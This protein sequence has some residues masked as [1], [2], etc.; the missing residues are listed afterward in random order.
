MKG[1]GKERMLT[2]YIP[3]IGWLR[4]Y[5]RKNLN[6][7]LSAGVTVAIMLVPQS[8]AY[9][10]LAGLP[11]VIGLYSSTLPL[12]VYALFGTSRQLAVGPVAMVSLLVY[13]G[14]SQLATPGSS[15]YVSLVLLLTL[16]TGLIQWI[17]GLLR[18]GFIV[19]FLSHAVISGFTSAAAI[20]I[21]L[22]Q[23]KHLLGIKLS[24]HHS[25]FSL[26]FEAVQK[27]HQIHLITFFLGLGSIGLL[28]L[29]KKN[30]SRFPA[31]LLVVVISTMLVYIFRLDRYGVNIVGNV[32]GGIPKP[33]FPALNL[34]SIRILLPSAFT[35]VFVGFMESIA[36]AQSIAVKEK[37]TVNANQEFFGL[38]L[39]NI[40]SALLSGY[41]V[42]GGFSRTAVNYQAG[43]R[44]GLASVI[45]AILIIGTL[46]FLTPLFYYLPNSV[47]A[48]IIM[49]AVYGLVDLKEARRLF[50]LKKVD[51]WTLLLTFLW[52]LTLGI[53]Q[54]I[55]LGVLFSLLVFIWR[56]AHPH[57]AELGYVESEKAFLNIKRFAEAKTFPGTLILRVDAAMF[58]ANTRFI[59]NHVRE[60]LVEKPEVTHVV[61]DLS[62]VNDI[63][64]VAISE[65]Q[66]LVMTYREQGVQFAFAG[67]KGPVRDLFLKA[68][69]QKTCGHKIE[70]RSLYH[71]MQDLGKF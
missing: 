32:P 57:M 13:V 11:P 3:A 34:E 61:F 54:G 58:F 36:V 24:S 26:L 22:S 28:V 4:N 8:M 7:D 63:D 47:L 65:L 2:K 41:P 52:T 16:M 53:E 49:V 43:A 17:L 42:T 18:M 23:L 5:H 64:A 19:N 38:G 9:A 20:V 39:A 30:A 46:L 62:A 37:Y 40:A 29:L 59:E 68:G 10:M 27:M 45:T 48:A 31:P 55:I 70:Y 25:I 60:S 35:I 69:W 15:E 12:I 1:G 33:S 6:G 14:T 67:M 51:G 50:K 21:G 66:D 71:V 44:T 56:S